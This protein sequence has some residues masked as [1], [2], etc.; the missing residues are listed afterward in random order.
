MKKNTF[1]AALFFM[2]TF[3]VKSQ[4][5]IHYYDDFRYAGNSGYTG[6]VTS[7]PQELGLATLITRVTDVPSDESTAPGTSVLAY[8][9]PLNNIGART[10]VRNPRAIKMAGNTGGQNYEAVT[11]SVMD[12]FDIS[13]LSNLMVTFAVKNSFQ[14]GA[15]DDP[16]KVL[17]AK[18]Y[19]DGTTP[20][21]GTS[22]GEFTD[23]TASIKTANPSFGNDGNWTFVTFNLSDYIDD[24]GA[25]KFA[26]AFKYEF[27]NIGDFNASTNRN[28]T[29]NISDVKFFTDN[30]LS[31]ARLDSNSF[32]IFPNPTT[33]FI[34]I[35]NLKNI[36]IDT[37]S[38]IDV[39]SKIVYNSHQTASIDTKKLNRGIYF[40]KITSA[41]NAVLTKKVIIQ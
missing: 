27:H 41:N 38:L 1:I 39:T 22:F 9:R 7:D 13:S 36:N 35:K 25:D 5:T 16:F 11:W 32:S 34:N 37:I 26:L 31:T 3:S 20:V 30:T 40:L 15:D 24:T 18:N 17:I 28:G 33:D 8:T 23:I 2:F 19:T 6:F 29:W 10:D 21:E 4:E 14:E 12:A